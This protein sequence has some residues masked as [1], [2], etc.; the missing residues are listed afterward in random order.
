MKLLFTAPN[1]KTSVDHVCGALSSCTRIE[2]PVSDRG[3]P[4]LE[5]GVMDCESADKTTL[6]LG[7]KMGRADQHSIYYVGLDTTLAIANVLEKDL[8]PGYK[9]P[10]LL[11]KLAAGGFCAIKNGKGFYLW[12][13]GKKTP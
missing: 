7:H 1:Y 6:C 4:V 10:G 3:G 2:I 11:C 12:E 13:N 5:E 8:G 9:A